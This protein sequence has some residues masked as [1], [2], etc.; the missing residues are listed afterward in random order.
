METLHPGLYMIEEAGEKPIEGVSNSTGAFVGV[1]ER[2]PV[3]RSTVAT[4]WNDF[5]KHYGGYIVDSY[6]AYAVRGFFENGGARAYISRVV[7]YTDGNP[8]SLAST[9]DIQD[10]LGGLA[11]MVDAKYHGTYGD[12]IAVEVSGWNATVNTF[13]FKVYDNGALIEKYEDVSL[14]TIEDAVN[15][16]SNLV[17][18]TV[19]DDTLTL[20]DGTTDLSGGNDGRVGLTANDYVGDSS[21]HNGLYAFDNDPINIV[22]IPGNGDDAV[23]A[24]LKAYVENRKD[25]YALWNVPFG[26]GVADARTYRLDNANLNSDRIALYFGWLKVSD[27]IGAGKN[28][29]KLIPSVGHIAGIYARTDAERGVWKAPAGLEADVR[30]TI[31]IDYS[32]NDPEQDLLNPVGIN[33]IRSFPGSGLVVWGTR[34]VSSDPEYKYVPVRRSV[35]YVEQSILAGTRWSVFEP[36]DTE[37]YDK[38]RT[39]IES[40]LHGYWRSGGLKGATEE[41]AYFVQ[42]DATT[43]SPEDVD[44][45]KVFCVIGLA[46]RKPAEFIIF[47]VSLRK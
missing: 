33:V 47:R 9:A 26:K 1:T 11:M 13:D 42:C 46:T 29:T 22:A 17:S 10:T 5:V 23:L 14:A 20:A 35:D 30:G 39:S 12:R 25:C 4:S 3:G 8:T 41:E 31:G 43:T 24:G 7:H 27:P 36:N 40:F 28:P 16:A 38:L 32:V 34:S 18:I 37:L 44:A 45:G 2:G 6:L 21:S 19:I 15:P